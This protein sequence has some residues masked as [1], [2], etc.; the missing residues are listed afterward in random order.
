[1]TRKKAVLSIAQCRKILGQV[2][3][4]LEVYGL[5][6]WKEAC[7]SFAPIKYSE[8]TRKKWFRENLYRLTAAREIVDF[9]DSWVKYLRSKP[10]LDNCTVSSLRK[11]LINGIRDAQQRTNDKHGILNS[12]KLSGFR[13]LIKWADNKKELELGPY[14]GAEEVP[15]DVEYRPRFRKRRTPAQQLPPTVI[16]VKNYEIAGC[17]ELRIG[18]AVINEGKYPHQNVELELEIDKK[19]QVYG[20]DPFSWS[21]SANR[22]RIGFL[23]AP[24]NSDKSEIEIDLRLRIREASS[25][26]VIGGT[27]FFDDFEK[28]E[29]ASAKIGEA[30]IL[31]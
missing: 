7:R 25:R 28:L 14:T 16:L 8:D 6:S 30:E 19:L 31:L 17:D 20:V 21:P 15:E 11:C 1:M 22:I 27:I 23:F 3:K 24:I 29:R 18:I 5:A 12:V 2:T 13:T 26:Y 4:D 9:I 10:E